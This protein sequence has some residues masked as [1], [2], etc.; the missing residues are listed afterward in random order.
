M[1]HCT[2][3]R[4]VQRRSQST[5]GTLDLTSLFKCNH[6]NADCMRGCFGCF[7]TT[8]QLS[9]RSQRERLQFVKKNLILY[10]C[11]IQVTLHDTTQIMHHYY[12]FICTVAATYSSIE[13]I[14]NSIF[15]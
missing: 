10:H 5:R 4:S 13:L 11:Y 14:I 1:Q 12:M 6:R 2:D 7:W 15:L 8:A 3:Q 9:G